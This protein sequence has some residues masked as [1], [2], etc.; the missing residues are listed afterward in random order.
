MSVDSV[1]VCGVSICNFKNVLNGELSFENP[2]KDYS[3]SVLGLY[4]QNGSGK[5]A[6]ID[7]FALLKLALCSRPIPAKYVNYINVDSE[8]C[9]MA[10][11]FSIIKNQK[12]FKA[13]YSFSLKSVS[14][15]LE[16]NLDLPSVSNM[17][18][19]ICIF[20]EVLKCSSY[21][22]EEQGRLITLIDS[23][24]DEVFDPKP[25]KEFLVGNEK[26]VNT[27]LLVAKKFCSSLSRSFVFSRELLEAIKNRMSKT[28]GL[29][30][31][32]FYYGIIQRLVNFGNNELF[33]INTSNSGLISLNLLP[34]VFKYSDANTNAL[35]TITLSLVKPETINEKDKQLITKVI[36]S[37]DVV[38]KQ[39]IPG[40]SIKVKDLGKQVMQNGEV[41]NRIQFM[42]VR[43]G[44]VIP[45][46]YESEGIKKIIS[47]LQLLIVVYN[48]SSITVAIDELDSGVFEYLLG[49]LIRIISENG[50]GQLIFTS[51]NLRPLETL[52]RGFVA[53]TTMNPNNRYVRMTGVKNNNNLRDFYYRDIMLGGQREELYEPTSNSEIALSFRE[54]GEECGS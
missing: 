26:G 22:A 20:N 17:K 1:R 31:L 44:K 21:S 27:D 53:F 3:A 39:I 45:L 43:D 46:E 2:R 16:T 29:E 24:S 36:G 14:D 13:K 5:T 8:I 12:E 50:R 7:S 47:I 18:K 32:G 23:D 40:L 28:D 11:D 54:A 51:H 49:E 38:L 9:A 10:F 41:G 15:V 52:D 34:F 25:R 6:L 30:E 33:V 35:G 37:M 48:Q 42:S 19:R 4:G